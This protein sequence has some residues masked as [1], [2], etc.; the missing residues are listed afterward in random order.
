MN[1]SHLAPVAIALLGASL[2]TAILSAEP[3]TDTKPA[4]KPAV[5]KTDEVKP[6]SEKANEKNGKPWRSLFNGKDLTNWKS[7]NFG[8]EGEVK[9]NAKEKALVL[10]MGSSLTGV[11]WDPGEDVA[12]LPKN[13]YEIELQARRTV[14]NDFFCG[15]TFPYKDSHA[16]LVLGGWGGGVVGISCID[17]YDASENDTT[18][19]FNFKQNQWYKVRM[20][21]TEGKFN[22]WIDDK[23][24]VDVDLGDS[25]VGVRVEVELSR[26]LGIASFTTTSEIRNVRIRPVAPKP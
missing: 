5:G 11:T 9:I 13:N 15:L 16:T 24:F 12:P 17:H 21:V 23:S 7:T 19:Y 8:G 6:Q 10:S 20:R 4:T 18:N 14:G 1:R 3:P 26:P 25:K 22:A 2:F